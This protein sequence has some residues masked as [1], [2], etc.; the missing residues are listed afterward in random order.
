MLS[1]SLDF[2]TADLVSGTNALELL[3]LNAPMDYPPVVANIDLLLGTSGSA[4]PSPTPSP[5][6]VNGTCG[7]ANGATVSS[8]P[9]T[10]LCSTGTA[11]FVPGLG[12]APTAC[13]RAH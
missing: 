6:A 5:A 13:V 8:V 2:P 4:S 12:P 1:L 9:S 11:S 10:N 3:P 7:S